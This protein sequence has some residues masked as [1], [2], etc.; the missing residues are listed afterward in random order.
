[1]LDYQKGKGLPR[2]IYLHI[3]AGITLAAM[4]S[5]ALLVFSGGETRALGP[6][7]EASSYFRVADA[8]Q[9]FNLPQRNE[10]LKYLP[11]AKNVRARTTTEIFSTDSFQNLY[12]HFNVISFASVDETHPLVR[13]LQ[14]IFYL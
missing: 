9:I 13:I 3:E 10:S 4:D 7:D 12:V 11:G 8:M 14:V 2:A 5:N 6:F 1:L